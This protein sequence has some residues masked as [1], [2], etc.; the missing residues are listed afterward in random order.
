MNRQGISRSISNLPAGRQGARVFVGLSGGV[1]SAVSAALLKEQG[2]DVTGVFIKVWQ[3]DWLPCTWREER[4]D[5]MRVAARLDIPFLFFDFADEYK[6]GVADY[7]IEEY[8]R[9]RTPNPDVMCNKEVKFGAFAKRAREMGADYIATGH[10]L[11]GAND[12][13]YFLWTL[14]KED[15]KH[16]LFPVGHME[17][18]EVRKLAQE[19]DIPVAEKKDSQGICFLGNIDMEEFLSHFIKTSPGDVLS[20]EGDMIG[21][22]KGALYYTLGERHGFDIHKKSPSALPYFVIAKDMQANTITVSNDRAKIDSALPTRVKV[23]SANWLERPNGGE[24]EAQI[25]YRG[26]RMRVTLEGDT[27]AFESPQSANAGQSIV[28][29]EGDKCLG[30][31]VIGDIV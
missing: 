17:K 26:E 5:A 3:P 16:S 7:M 31:A 2:Y 21:K 12:Q 29:Y 22:H 28:F 30:G 11:S 18:S 9:G 25:R 27:V 15:W 13:R 1:D 10:Y 4:R 19:F 23:E 24:L 6:K 14:T 20:M 8:K